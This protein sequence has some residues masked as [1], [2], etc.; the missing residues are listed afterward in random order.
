MIAQSIFFNAFNVLFIVLDQVSKLLPQLESILQKWIYYKRVGNPE[1]EVAKQHGFAGLTA[2]E[3][4][5]KEIP[6][7]EFDHQFEINGQND[8]FTVGLDLGSHTTK[9]DVQVVGFKL[10]LWFSAPIGEVAT[11]SVFYPETWLWHQ[12]TANQEVFLASPTQVRITSF[13]EDGAGAIPGLTE[14]VNAWKMSLPSGQEFPPLNR[15]DGIVM[16]LN[17]D[18]I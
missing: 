8:E 13:R 3:P 18:E 10:D 2:T 14:R 7:S 5:L 9:S 11:E 15:V 16:V 6:L 4:L 1:K 17:L 12:T